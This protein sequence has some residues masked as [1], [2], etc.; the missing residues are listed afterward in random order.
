MQIPSP[1]GRRLPGF[2]TAEMRA[3]AL[4]SGALVFALTA[5]CTSGG[6]TEPSSRGAGGSSK[7]SFAPSVAAAECPDDIESSI[8][9]PHEC[10]YLTVLED[11]TRPDGPKIRLFYLRV[12]PEGG[13]TQPEP[14]ASVGQEIAQP[15][16]YGTNVGIAESSGRELILLNQRGV[17]YSQPSLACPEVD[18]VASDLV[19]HPLSSA[20]VRDAFDD[21]VSACRARLTERG[22]HPSSY[23]LAAA[24]RDLEDLRHALGVSS[25]NLMAWGSASRLLLE[26]ARRDQQGVRALVLD[27]PRFPEL[28]PISEAG[29]D[30]RDALEALAE[31]CRASKGCDRRYPHVEQALSQA[32]E[33]LDRSPITSSVHGRTVVV[34]GGA[35]V[36]VARHL[37]SGD[38]E[39]AGSVPQVVY[40]ALDGDVRAVAQVLADD[41]GLCVGY[42]PRC[43]EDPTSL[44]AY[45]SF[46]CSDAPASLEG[47]GVYTRA[48]GKADPY[49]GACRAWG[50]EP[51][52]DHPAPVRTDAPVLVLRGAY[53]AFSPLDL[54]RQATENMPNAHVVLVPHLGHDVF[55]WGYDCLRDTRNDWL[56]NPQVAPDFAAC[57]KT[58]PPPTFR[59]SSP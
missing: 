56:L 30:T 7:A 34:D 25:W 16:H 46:T 17:G 45:L 42:L 53:D 5:A 26:Y 55:A 2:G 51:G 11:R 31:T 12:Q 28:D 14:I 49:L 4:A 27:A 57:L 43:G 29:P 10:G 59:G 32:A 52:G 54:V 44:G 8:L 58:I 1:P 24:A 40:R 37:V 41:P 22:V 9:G 15:P 18:E 20:S 38:Q 48:F 47:S 23:T 19:A 50:V 39:G 6:S 33:A 13:P 21:A 3:R 36:R 35:L